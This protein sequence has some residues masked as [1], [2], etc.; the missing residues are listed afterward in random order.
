MAAVSCGATSSGCANSA[1]T[2][3][4]CTS[5]FR[6]P[7]NKPDGLG[8]GLLRTVDRVRRQ[9]EEVAGIGGGCPITGSEL[10]ELATREQRI[11]ERVSGVIHARRARTVELQW[12][13]ARAVC[14]GLG[15]PTW[16]RIGRR[17]R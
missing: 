13:L 10:S 6:S 8:S 5:P 14:R 12:L 1:R 9:V 17:T 16:M 7:A 3:P 11:F 4:R 15:E 2:S